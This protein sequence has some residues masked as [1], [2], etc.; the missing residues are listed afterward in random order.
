MYIGWAAQYYDST[1]RPV[2]VLF[3][4]AFFAVFALVPLLTPLTRSRWHP[5]MSITLTL[6]PLVNGGGVF[7]GVVCD[8]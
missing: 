7:P 4:S 8:V 5:G 6:L 1:E 2:T 3:A